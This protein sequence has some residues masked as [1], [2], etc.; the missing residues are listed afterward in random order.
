V[1]GWVSREDLLCCPPRRA[2]PTE[3]RK[4]RRPCWHGPATGVHDAR[5][6]WRLARTQHEVF[7]RAGHPEVLGDEAR[8]RQVLSNWCPS[9]ATTA[10][11]GGHLR[12][13][14]TTSTRGAF[15]VALRG[16][17]DRRGRQTGFVV[18]RAVL[19]PQTRRAHGSAVDLVSGLSMWT[20]WLYAHGGT[21]RSTTAPGKGAVHRQ[22]PRIAAVA[23]RSAGRLAQFGRAALI[24]A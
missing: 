9:V 11:V 5:F 12:R 7:G 1:A 18:V 14:A 8:L 2:A 3:K 10:G 15:E 21:V 13:A 6:G 17:H 16:R 22:M 23:F 19:S 24:L 4:P 20:P